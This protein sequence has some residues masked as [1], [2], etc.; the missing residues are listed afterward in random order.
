MLNK[1]KLKKR[2]INNDL[3]ELGISDHNC[4]I[5][6]KKI[7]ERNIH[8]FWHIYN[9]MTYNQESVHSIAACD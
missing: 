8:E 6:T 3:F 7:H 1:R 5:G 9:T 2:I 4:L